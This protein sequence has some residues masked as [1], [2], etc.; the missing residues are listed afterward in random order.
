MLAKNPRSLHVNEITI[1]YP[2]FFAL[3]LNRYEI[4]LAIFGLYVFFIAYRLTNERLTFSYLIL[5]GLILITTIPLYTIG[6]DRINLESPYRSMLAMIF[7][8]V[9]A[10]L[11]FQRQS[12]PI[13]YN[14]IISYIIGIGISSII[15]SG[16]SVYTNPLV[17]GYG[18]LYNPFTDKEINSPGV[19]NNLAIF[20]SLLIYLLFKKNHTL[21]KILIFS[22]LIFSVLMAVSLGGRT[23]FLIFFLTLI[24]VSSPIAS[25]FKIKS[26]AI[27]LFILILIFLIFT[28]IINNV[29]QFEGYY[30]FMTQRFEN[31]LESKR[32]EHYL[33]GINKLLHYPFGGFYTDQSIES[34]KYFHNVFIDNARL[35]GWLP[36][37]TLILMISFIATSFTGLKDIHSNFGSFIFIVCLLIMQQDVI[38][39]GN[40]QP[41][42][43]MYYSGILISRQ[44]IM[45]SNRATA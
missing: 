36:T 7:S 31:G 8:T 41:L 16:Y 11:S 37:F 13:Q 4:Y 38:I 2:A 44:R 3:G 23:Y 20:S 25:K 35:A 29:E 1:L 15:I 6:H 40:S 42:V 33:D 19:S 22:A 18:V 30:L 27:I 32:Y 14:L 9:I 39:E 26:L 10:G 28:W 24:V 5:S 45:K 17:Y 43:L 12:K 34:T 21:Y